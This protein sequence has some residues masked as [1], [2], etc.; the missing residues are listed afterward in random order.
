MTLVIRKPPTPLP[1]HQLMCLGVV[2]FPHVDVFFYQVPSRPLILTDVPPLPPPAWTRR[3]TTEGAL[4][5]ALQR[6][7]L[8]HTELYKKSP[9]LTFPTGKYTHTRYKC[10]EGGDSIPAAAPAD[11][12]PPP[13]FSAHPS[14]LVP[15]PDPAVAPNGL[16]P[17]LFRHLL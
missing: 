14:P 1:P 17:L 3:N 16:P 15:D 8:F 12:L 4:L 6:S 2:S 10:D 9:L 13:R 7:K 11:A 5:S